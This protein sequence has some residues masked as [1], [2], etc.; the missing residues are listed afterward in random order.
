MF[1]RMDRYLGRAVI[2]AYVATALTFVLIVVLFDLLA[3]AG[4]YLRVANES[5]DIST[6]GLI[7]LLIEFYACWLPGMFLSFAPYVTVI[8]SM[9]A[10]SKLTSANEIVPMVFS[11]R[12]MF[13]VL[14]PVIAIA[15]ASTLAMG[16]VWEW[17]APMMSA[18]FLILKD[19]L[20]QGRVD[21]AAK[22]VLV[23]AGSGQQVLFCEKYRH[24][25]QQMEDV[26]VYDRGAAGEGPSIYRARFADWE[27]DGAGR[28][29]LREGVRRHGD[30]IVPW[31]ALAL[32]G[33]TPD[34]V[35]HLSRGSHPE[36][37]QLL[38]YSELLRLRELRPG[39]HD[40]KL[41]FH[42]HITM[43]LAN[44]ILV[45]LTLPLAVYFERGSRAER[46]VFAILV[47]AAYLVFDLTSRSLG[48]RQFVDPAV[49]AWGPVIVFGAFG[50][51]FYSS[52]RT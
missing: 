28:W 37:V 20:E 24:R 35:W 29:V 33:I 40:L 3:N 18:R 2:E 31:P 39:R 46:V 41:Q 50:A 51:V 38:S 26:T 30:R 11:G 6:L 27:A 14:R 43:P 21:D 10:V 16:A 22:G 52:V 7:G 44:I 25:L 5:L 9:F 36:Q 42:V 17:V 12:S 34:T 8:A 45:L 49:A 15:V 47:C 32:P 48:L 23:H 4:Q 13:R 19:M 1:G